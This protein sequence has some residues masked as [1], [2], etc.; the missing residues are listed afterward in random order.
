MAINAVTKDNLGEVINSGKVAVVDF[1]AEWCKPCK[2]MMPA[3][4][5]ADLRFG[6][7]VVFAKCN[8]DDNPQIASQFGIRG[9]PAIVVFKG[10]KMVD[11][12]NGAMTTGAI[13][14]LVNKH[15]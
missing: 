8:V 13:E 15:L 14:T 9:I 7:E 1:W 11:M 3:F 10:G 12:V 6:D 5:A 4:E 2:A